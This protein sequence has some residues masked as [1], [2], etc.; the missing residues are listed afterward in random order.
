M[1]AVSMLVVMLTNNS[2][3][4][5]ELW[6]AL[7]RKPYQLDFLSITDLI[8]KHQTNYVGKKTVALAL[9]HLK[10]HQIGNTMILK[11]MRDLYDAEYV[12]AFKQPS[13]KRQ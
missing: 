5:K 11:D 2:S 4:M 12:E 13:N 6:T 10:C 1:A 8:E 3:A 7:R 9:T